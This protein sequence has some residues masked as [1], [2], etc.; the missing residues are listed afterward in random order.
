[1]GSTTRRKLRTLREIIR[2]IA[3]SSSSDLSSHHGRD[4]KGFDFG[5]GNILRT[6]LLF[7]LLFLDTS[8]SEMYSSICIMGSLLLERMEIPCSLEQLSPRLD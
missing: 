2:K 1:M 6:H 4:L 8:I 7:G 5:E 3:H